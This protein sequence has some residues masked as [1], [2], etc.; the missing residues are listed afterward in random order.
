V[1]ATDDAGPLPSRAIEEAL[2]QGWVISCAFDNDQAGDKRWQHVRELYPSAGTIVRDVPPAPG[3]DWNDALRASAGQEWDK[4][5]QPAHGRRPDRER[6][7][8][9][10]LEPEKDTRADQRR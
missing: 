9:A 4:G 6:G 3:K 5:Q 2:A 10:R 7:G 8:D 1:A